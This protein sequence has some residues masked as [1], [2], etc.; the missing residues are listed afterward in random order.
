[1]EHNSKAIMLNSLQQ[2]TKK[3]HRH[4]K[5]SCHG[6][7]A[8]NILYNRKTGMLNSLQQSTNKLLKDI[9]SFIDHALV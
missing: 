2:S 6:I 4:F 1:M 3:L 5:F 9:G 8:N 7:H